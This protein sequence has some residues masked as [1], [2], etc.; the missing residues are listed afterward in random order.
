MGDTLHKVAMKVTDLMFELWDKGQI[1]VALTR[2]KF[3]KNI[4]LVGQKE[5]TVEA[6]V[7]FVQIRSQWTN[8][9]ESVLDLITENDNNLTRLLTLTQSSF[10]FLIFNIALP[11]C[12]T[13]FVYFLISIKSRDYTYI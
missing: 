5:E 7:R 2:T 3:G 1:V 9:M 11:H 10:P 13:G 12:K 4:I 6:I 8:F